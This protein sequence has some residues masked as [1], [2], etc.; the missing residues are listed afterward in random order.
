MVR[1]MRSNLDPKLLYYLYIIFESGS[2]SAAADVLTVS[3]PTLSRAVSNL[4][5][6]VG[7]Q[8]MVRGRN[9]V[10]LTEI[11][12]SLAEQGRKIATDLK[13]ADDVLNALK[14]EAPDDPHRRRSA[15]CASGDERLRIA[16][17]PDRRAVQ[18]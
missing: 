8:L 16:G 5:A 11:G 17:N 2:L 7:R 12:I 3:Q 13:Q 18:L 10:V 1:Q 9:G 15:A 4:E 6:L 14:S